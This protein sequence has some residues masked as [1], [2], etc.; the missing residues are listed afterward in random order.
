MGRVTRRTTRRT[1]SDS[2]FAPVECRCALPPNKPFQLTPLRVDRDRGDFA[3][4][5]QIE[6]HFD[7]LVRRS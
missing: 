1:I 7:L 3:R 6:Y 2:G 5:N 4:Q